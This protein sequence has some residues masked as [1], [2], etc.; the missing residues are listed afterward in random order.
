MC[1]WNRAGR[2]FKRETDMLQDP[3]GIATSPGR[4]GSSLFPTMAQKSPPKSDTV[5]STDSVFPLRPHDMT[6]SEA[7]Q[8]S[9]LSSESN[10]FLPDIGGKFPNLGSVA[11]AHS[12]PMLEKEME[13]FEK[14]MHLEVVPDKASDEPCL[15]GSSLSD[16]KQ[17]HVNIGDQCIH[18][19]NDPFVSESNPKKDSAE[20]K[21]IIDSKTAEEKLPIS[22]NEHENERSE[23]T[24]QEQSVTKLS[25]S[26]TEVTETEKKPASILNRNMKSKIP[27]NMMLPRSLKVNSSPVDKLAKDTKQ[28][29][30]VATRRF[31]VDKES[32]L[33]KRSSKHKSNL[34]NSNGIVQDP[35]SCKLQ[36]N[37]EGIQL[38]AESVSSTKK[39]VVEWMMGFVRKD[40]MNTTHSGNDLWDL[41]VDMIR[42]TEIPPVMLPPKNY[43]LQCNYTPGADDSKQP[44]DLAPAAS[45]SKPLPET[46]HQ[47]ASLLS[48]STPAAEL[49]AE[50]SEVASVRAKDYSKSDIQGN[51]SPFASEYETSQETREITGQVSL[52]VAQMKNTWS[53][54]PSEH[55]IREIKLQSDSNQHSTSTTS[56][57]TEGTNSKV[58]P[59]DKQSLN[60]ESHQQDSLKR[61]GN[62]WSSD[63]SPFPTNKTQTE[64]HVMSQKLYSGDSVGDCEREVDKVL[65]RESVSFEVKESKLHLPTGMSLACQSSISDSFNEGLF[66]TVQTYEEDTSSLQDAPEDRESQSVAQKS[67]TSKQKKKSLRGSKGRCGTD[68]SNV[69]VVPTRRSIRLRSIEKRKLTESPKE[70]TETSVVSSRKRQWSSHNSDGSPL[71]DTSESFVAKKCASCD[72][73]KESKEGPSSGEKMITTYTELDKED[74]NAKCEAVRDEVQKKT[75]AETVQDDSVTQILSNDTKSPNMPLSAVSPD[76]QGLSTVTQETP[77]ADTGNDVAP[78]NGTDKDV[79]SCDVTSELILCHAD[80]VKDICTFEALTSDVN[81]ASQAIPSVDV[82]KTS[83]TSEFVI[84]ADMS[85]PSSPE[86]TTAAINNPVT[87]GP[88]ILSAFIPCTSKDTTENGHCS[89]EVDMLHS[90]P[91]L[92]TT[93][94]TDDSIE[95]NQNAEPESVE[96]SQKTNM[97]VHGILDKDKQS[98]PLEASEDKVW[99]LSVNKN[100]DESKGQDGK[101]IHALSKDDGK[102]ELTLEKHLNMP[103]IVNKNRVLDSIQPTAVDIG[104]VQA[105]GVTPRTQQQECLGY[106]DFVAKNPFFSHSDE[107][108]CDVWEENFADPDDVTVKPRPCR[109]EKVELH[110]SE[111]PLQLHESAADSETKQSSDATTTSTQDVDVSLKAVLEEKVIESPSEETKE[112]ASS[113]QSWGIITGDE[114]PAYE[115]I[116]ENCYVSERKKSKAGKEARRMIC[117]CTTSKSERARGIPACGDDCLNRL[118]LIECT[119]RCPCGDYCTNKRFSKRQYADVGVFYAENKGHGLKTKVDLKSHEFV[120]EYCGEV[121]NYTEFKS[122]VK[123]Y[124]KDNQRHFYFMA[125]RADEIIDATIKGNM[126]R[127]INHSCDPNCETQKWT[128]NGQIRVGFFTK[129]FI[130][131]GTELTF[132]YQFEQYGEHAQKCLCGSTNCRGFIGKQKRT[133]KATGK[134]ATPKRKENLDRRRKESFEDASL[135]DEIEQL[136]SELDGGGLRT[137]DQT[138]TLARHMVLAETTPLRLQLLKILEDTTDETCLKHFLTHH[139]LKLLWSWMVDIGDKPE[140]ELKMEILHTLMKLPIPHKNALE[141][142]KIFSMVERWSKARHASKAETE[143][144]DSSASET[145]SRCATPVSLTIASRNTPTDMV[146]LTDS[147]NSESDGDLDKAPLKQP[148]MVEMPENASA[149]PIQCEKIETVAYEIDQKTEVDSSTS[150]VEGMDSSQSVLK[151]PVCSESSSVT[152]SEIVSQSV[153]S[154]KIKATVEVEAMKH[155]SV[156]TDESQMPATMT[157]ETQS[158]SLV[159]SV[160]NP[161]SDTVTNTK[162]S[163]PEG[164]SASQIVGDCGT[165][166]ETKNTSLEPPTEPTNLEEGELPCEQTELKS[167]DKDKRQASCKQDIG[168][169]SDLADAGTKVDKTAGIASVAGKLL[170]AWRSL[171]EIYRIPKNRDRERDRDYTERDRDRDRDRGHDRDRRYGR[172][173]EYDRD[174]DRDRDRDRDRHRDRESRR[175]R[176]RERDRYHDRDRKRSWDRREDRKRRSRSASKDREDKQPAQTTEKKDADTSKGTLPKLRKPWKIEA[177]T[178]T[179][180]SQG[181]QAKT[182]RPGLSKEERRQ[183]FAKQVEQADMEEELRKRQEEEFLRQHPHFIDEDG[184]IHFVDA[185]GFPIAPPFDGESNHPMMHMMHLNQGV[186]ME[187]TTVPPDG[188]FPHQMNQ[189][190]PGYHDMIPHPQEMVPVDEN[191]MPIPVHGQPAFENSQPDM[192]L[193]QDAL[194]HHPHGLE[195]PPHVV[196]AEGMHVI[197]DQ[198]LQGWEPT[199]PQ[200]HHP[201]TVLP[202]SQFRVPAPPGP[203]PNHIPVVSGVPHP[204]Y[205]VPQQ[206]QS[207]LHQVQSAALPAQPHVIQQQVVQPQPKPTAPAQTVTFVTPDGMLVTQTIMP[208]NTESNVQTNIHQAQQIQQ[209]LNQG[210][211]SPPSKPKTQQLP[212]NWRTA[213]DQEG[214]I[215]Y[216]HA[217]T[218]QTQWDMPSWDGNAPV[219]G[220]P[221]TDMDL[222]TPTYDEKSKKRTT[223]AAAD[224]SSELAKRCKLQFRSKMSHYV[225]SCLNTYRKPDCKVGRITS[226]EDFKHLARKLTHGIMDKELKHCKNFEDLEVNSNVKHKAKEYIKKYMMHVGP[227]YH[228]DD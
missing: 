48:D 115:N 86:V 24:R 152:Q 197:A 225:I 112:H 208:L 64:V 21:T 117:D 211:P 156:T 39:P 33:A 226:T 9:S 68:E 94:A 113:S 201:Q 188:V 121:L 95:P 60:E 142:S 1:T 199:P 184:Q 96:I 209:Q 175:A 67:E 20:V 151:S 181:K 155:C 13:E 220:G 224:T 99:K 23:R 88:T 177:A 101:H 83:L 149:F 103:N 98:S 56:V 30:T 44:H 133:S 227:V 148:V 28:L 134:D 80:E 109:K 108:T 104:H 120:M 18:A 217:I 161:E 55:E 74:R 162:S 164:S 107:F 196:P 180:G 159:T 202:Q 11:Y 7:A 203:N 174:Y 89:A 62:N 140:P 141:D 129:K 169:D 114:I 176:S 12:K 122:R 172:D 76:T 166:T 147:L 128:V 42:F 205:T 124:N 93:L 65:Q 15:D 6:R 82:S 78:V 3:Q 5:S 195:G 40:T 213:R 185:N 90:P 144:E 187:H 84:Y 57:S 36:P 17:P 49:D 212:P 143:V 158:D 191:G 216:Y 26:P 92:C 207:Q 123:R 110:Q 66:K 194:M 22:E 178:K 193:P 170:E 10:R 32:S 63:I 52:Q 45:C 215:Y 73:V 58:P 179:E 72:P 27:E 157:S 106:V 116:P 25:T 210:I 50:T 43:L 171:K 153:E 222:G 163:S 228:K 97:E 160:S 192:G 51:A 111:A 168:S 53:S 223:T 138:L 183:R 70:F 38:S 81:L 77:F 206:P 16:D 126:S 200:G 182:D 2:R 79:S 214:K 145:L 137:N 35:P 218:R 19:L 173:R 46:S 189:N 61:D 41:D 219:L 190:H 165:L 131:A 118:L 102:E 100:N 130:A 186:P 127:F 4:A 59:L 221:E 31:G 54:E 69:E 14:L 204:N 105:S 150:I 8:E 139:G 34:G 146:K 29:Y 167:E 136:C 71:D 75:I 119:S 85:S 135:D 87:T 198:D 132:D 154:V 47:D 125:L 37:R 91:T